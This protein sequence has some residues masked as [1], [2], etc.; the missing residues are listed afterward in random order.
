MRKPNQTKPN[1]TKPFKLINSVITFFLVFGLALQPIQKQDLQKN[2]IYLAPRSEII[3]SGLLASFLELNKKTQK[4]PAEKQE[5]KK[6][7]KAMSKDEKTQLLVKLIFSKEESSSKEQSNQ[8]AS[9]IEKE[10]PSKEDRARAKQEELLVKQEKLLAKWLKK[11]QILA[12]GLDQYRLLASL[13]ELKTIETINQNLIKLLTE[14]NINWEEIKQIYKNGQALISSAKISTSSTKKRKGKK[15]IGDTDPSFENVVRSGEDYEGGSLDS[16]QFG[17]LPF[18]IPPMLANFNWQAWIYSPTGLKAAIL[19]FVGTVLVTYI[20][21]KKDEERKKNAVLSSLKKIQAE[22]E[23]DEYEQLGK[24]LD[25]LSEK[26]EQAIIDLKS[27]LDGS[28]KDEKSEADEYEQLGKEL[29][30]LSEKQE[31]AIID[32]KS[33]LDGS[34]KDE[35]SEADEYEQLGKELDQLSEKQE[36][37]IIDLKSLL[38]GSKKDEKSEAD[39]YEQLGKELDQLS[40]KQ[41][42]AIIDLK[43]LLDGSKKDEKSEADEYE[44]LG[45]ELDQLS[46]KQEQAIIDLKSLL[47]RSKKDEKSEADEFKERGESVAKKEDQSIASNESPEKENSFLK[48]APYILGA[49]F[50][51]LL[52]FLPWRQFIAQNKVVTFFVAGF[53]VG[54]VLVTYILKKKDEEREKKAVLSAFKKIQAE[55]EA[56]EYEQLGK[57]LD[58]LQKNSEQLIIGLE[59]LL[60]EISL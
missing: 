55:W 21:K 49:E 1:Q 29:D 17:F 37:A 35:K 57:E 2:N 16:N 20:L 41:E 46:E 43:S 48:W 45:K 39:E 44:Q 15:G 32:L 58:Q 8:S 26:Q 11:Y 40:E 27:L 56:D 54:T 30:Q 9:A 33:L 60:T 3:S 42:Q 22:W 28:K 5:L 53:F 51:F 14:K 12:T 4:S 24:E 59:S 34:K 6:M 10:T 50:A 31:Q 7:L 25:Q 36:Q 47:D 13:N 19:L 18:L 23:A 38:D 52:T